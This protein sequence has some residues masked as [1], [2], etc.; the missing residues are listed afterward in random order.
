MG[1]I[2]PVKK[3]TFSVQVAVLHRGVDIKSHKIFMFT[4]ACHH[5][6]LHVTFFLWLIQY[7]KKSEVKSFAL[8]VKNRNFEL[9]AYR[10]TQYPIVLWDQIIYVLLSGIHFSL[11]NLLL[12]IRTNKLLKL[13]FITILLYTRKIQLIKIINAAC[14]IPKTNKKIQFRAI[15]WKPEMFSEGCH[16]NFLGRTRSRYAL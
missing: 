13:Y 15:L 9:W 14:V 5:H 11:W 8:V 7:I 12:Q 16:H 4:G 1:K 6:F 10:T 3:I 2:F